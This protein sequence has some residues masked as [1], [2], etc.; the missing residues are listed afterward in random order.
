MMDR[1]EIMIFMLLTKRPRRT[2]ALTRG[3][4][5]LGETRAGHGGDRVTQD[6]VLLTLD[7]QGVTQTVHAQFG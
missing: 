5:G 7:R 1:S 6:V 4:H 3:H 2:L